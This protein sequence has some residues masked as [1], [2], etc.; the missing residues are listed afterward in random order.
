[1]KFV[2]ATVVLLAALSPSWP[3]AQDAPAPSLTIKITSPL[4]R[5]GMSGPVRIVARIASAPRATL[6]PVQFFVDGKLLAEDKDGPPYA[7]EW[8]DKTPLVLTEIAVQV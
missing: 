7:V 2:R 6:G 3:S 5:T 8:S 4:G 1:M